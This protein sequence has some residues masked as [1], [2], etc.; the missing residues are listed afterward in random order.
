LGKRIW[1]RESI[2]HESGLRLVAYCDIGMDQEVV[3]E[4]PG[5][6][7]WILFDTLKRI[8]W[9]EGADNPGNRDDLKSRQLS[10]GLQLTCERAE[11]EGSHI[12]H[13][14]D[15]PIPANASDCLV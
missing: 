8:R 2:F 10:S 15:A 5:F 3:P 7:C 12:I 6:T 13:L 14:K 4:C 1:E 11:R 9:L